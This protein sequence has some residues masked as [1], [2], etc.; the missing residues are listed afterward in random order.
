[1]ENADILFLYSLL[2]KVGNIPRDEKV[3]IKITYVAELKCEVGEM[4][5]RFLLPTAV[6]PRY[7]PPPNDQ[8]CIP[9][10]LCEL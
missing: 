4:T 5:K 8:Q 9:S 1:M 7:L 6:A 3:V 10:Y 2:S